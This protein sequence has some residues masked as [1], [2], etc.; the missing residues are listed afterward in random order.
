MLGPVREW[1]VV[2]VID[3]STSQD[4]SFKAIKSLRLYYVVL[5]IWIEFMGDQRESIVDAL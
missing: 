5:W 1:Q 4:A 3:D 2:P